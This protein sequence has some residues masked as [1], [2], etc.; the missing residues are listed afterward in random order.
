[1][2]LMSYENE[3]VYTNEGR[4]LFQK[5]KRWGLLREDDYDNQLLNARSLDGRCAA[6]IAAQASHAS[7]IPLMALILI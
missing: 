5:K 6:A 4:R 7:P 3:V 2:A 1:M